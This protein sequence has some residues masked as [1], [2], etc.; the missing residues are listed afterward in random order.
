MALHY[1]DTWDGDKVVSHH[2][3]VEY[4]GPAYPV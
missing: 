3:G 4:A 1:F 2:E